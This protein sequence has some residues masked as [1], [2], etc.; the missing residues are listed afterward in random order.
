MTSTLQVTCSLTSTMSKKLAD[1]DVVMLSPI[2]IPTLQVKL[3]SSVVF[4]PMVQVP[5]ESVLFSKT[6]V[7]DHVYWRGLVGRCTIVGDLL[8]ADTSNGFQEVECEAIHSADPALSTQ[9]QTRANI[10]V[11]PIVTIVALG[12]VGDLTHLECWAKAN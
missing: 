9:E 11:S 3:C 4:S 10:H 1:T 2:P 12:C 8:Q 6:F 7:F 5:S